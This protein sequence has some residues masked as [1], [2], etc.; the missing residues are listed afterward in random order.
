MNRTKSS[1]FVQGHYG[2]PTT[3]ASSR[4][5]SPRGL[6]ILQSGNGRAIDAIGLSDQR[7]TLARFEPRKCFPPLEGIELELGPEFHAVV[8]ALCA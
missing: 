4:R 2:S 5:V 7:L 8:H 1:A 3:A 6:S